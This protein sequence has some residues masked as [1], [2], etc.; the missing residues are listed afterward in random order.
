MAHL[1][2]AAAVVL[3]TLR[4]YKAL[5]LETFTATVTNETA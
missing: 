3:A 2:S 4:N 1:N 5:A